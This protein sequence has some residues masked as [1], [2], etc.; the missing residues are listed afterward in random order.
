MTAPRPSKGPV[1]TGSGTRPTSLMR[2]T[3]ARIVEHSASSGPA[4]GTCLVERALADAEHQS[5]AAV[6]GWI[7]PYGVG[8]H[9]LRGAGE[10]P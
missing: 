1:R 10:E 3:A 7:C 6:P 9:V 4:V 5:P 2:R 8:R